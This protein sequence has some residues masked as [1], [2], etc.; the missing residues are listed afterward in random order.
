MRTQRDQPANRLFAA[1]DMGTGLPRALTRP[2]HPTSAPVGPT[3][4]ARKGRRIPAHR[5]TAQAQAARRCDSGT[6]S[7]AIGRARKITFDPATALLAFSVF[8][9]HPDTRVSLLPDRLPRPGAAG[10][11]DAR[12]H[13]PAHHPVRTAMRMPRHRRR[14]HPQPHSD[15]RPSVTRAPSRR[16]ATGEDSLADYLLTGRPPPART[17]RSACHIG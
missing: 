4:A 1:P 16:V 10:L 6:G 7:P 13:P 15:R 11:P 14:T 8:Q 9:D 3:S 17:T 12:L 5:P 2:R